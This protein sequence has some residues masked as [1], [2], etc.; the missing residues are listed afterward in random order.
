MDIY[1]VYMSILWKIFFFVLWDCNYFLLRFCVG[2]NIGLFYFLESRFCFIPLVWPANFLFDC[3]R[4]SFC[5]PFRFSYLLYLFKP[6]CIYSTYPIISL[7]WSFHLA[8]LQSSITTVDNIFVNR[9]E[10]PP[11][12]SFLKNLFTCSIKT[13][14]FHYFISADSNWD[15][16]KYLRNWNRRNFHA[17]E[18][19]TE[20]NRKKRKR[21]KTD[22]INNRGR[23]LRVRVHSRGFE[24]DKA[25]D[26]I[27]SNSRTSWKFKGA[28]IVHAGL[29][30]GVN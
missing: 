9:L 15:I 8:N 11:S 22:I 2:I 28:V 4:S 19:E 7:H 21:K 3:P 29:R 17:R 27:L 12:K 26:H 14:F 10:S 24:K 18:E 5:S 6:W 30:S 16:V 23:K 25:T 20:R 1:Y 13:R